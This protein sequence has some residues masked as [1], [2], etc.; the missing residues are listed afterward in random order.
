MAGK[1]VTRGS[2][3]VA[4]VLDD[5]SKNTLADLVLDFVQ[6]DI[7]DG[8]DDEAILTALQPR[9]DAIAA[10]RGDRPIDLLRRLCQFD[11]SERR[12]LAKRPAN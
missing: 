2:R 1:A 7:G 10:M 9:V 12:Y 11:A 5:L 3:R 8:A 6:G 4:R